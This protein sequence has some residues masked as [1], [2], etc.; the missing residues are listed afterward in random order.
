MVQ[1]LRSLCDHCRSGLVFQHAALHTCYLVAFMQPWFGAQETSFDALDTLVDSALL[2]MDP[3]A[4]AYL[5]HE[6]DPDVAVLMSYPLGYFLACGTS[7]K[8]PPSAEAVA[9]GY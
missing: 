9:Q 8:A 7:M 3:K 2:W 5:N 6:H 4:G 1:S